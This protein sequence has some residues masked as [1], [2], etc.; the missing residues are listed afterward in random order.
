MKYCT[1]YQKGVLA[2]LIFILTKFSFG[3]IASYDWKVLPTLSGIPNNG[4]KLKKSNFSIVVTAS[5]L[6]RAKI[7][8]DQGNYTLYS[9]L[10]SAYDLGFNYI[11]NV[12]NN[13]LL[14][15][16]IHT[17][18]GRWNFFANIPDEDI[19]VYRVSGKL[20][21]WNKDTWGIIKIP[22]LIEKKLNC[23]KIGLLSTKAGINF[24]YSGFNSDLGIG[25][26]GIITSNNQV[27][28]L[29]DSDFSIDNKNKPWITFLA[30]INKLF[31]LDNYNILSVGVQTDISP[32]YFLKG[33]YAITVP[34][35]SVTSGT[36]KVSGTSLGLSISYTFTGTNKRLVQ[37]YEKKRNL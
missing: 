16:G 27:I 8:R 22:L 6:P 5:V 24:R 19:S 10:Q 30:G 18:I 2:L 34:G 33:N 35:Q 15:T 7:T 1:K 3:Q 20:I 26:G 9:R 13:L 28:N 4:M 32:I 31:V 37:E 17:I 21:I 25:S 14:T 29:F 12:N 11:Y 23:R 36:Y